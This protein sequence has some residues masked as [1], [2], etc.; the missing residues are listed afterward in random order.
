M[1]PPFS[2]EGIAK[3]LCSEGSIKVELICNADYWGRW[4]HQ[5]RFLKCLDFQKILVACEG[6]SRICSK[7]NPLSYFPAR[8][9]RD[10]GQRQILQQP[11]AQNVRG[12]HACSFGQLMGDMTRSRRT[13]LSGLYLKLVVMEA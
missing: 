4:Y 7:E 3:K 6:T 10:T 13:R 5:Y 11:S 8:L 1:R 9:G 2:D 12:Q